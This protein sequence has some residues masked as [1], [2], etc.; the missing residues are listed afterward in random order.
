MTV[1]KRIWYTVR[2]IENTAL[3]MTEQVDDAENR[4]SPAF[5]ALFE[6][7]LTS[8][9]G[10]AGRKVIWQVRKGEGKWQNT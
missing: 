7:I 3:E 4:S 8:V 9:F 6:K 5:S 10:M 2:H 1:P